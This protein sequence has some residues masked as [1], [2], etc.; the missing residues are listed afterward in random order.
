MKIEEFFSDLEA[1]PCKGLPEKVEN[2]WE[3]VNAKNDFFGIPESKI[4]G[5]LHGS[6]VVEGKVEIGD[7]V[8]VGP[9][10]VIEGPVKIGKNTKIRSCAWIRPYTIIGEDCVVGHGCEVK[11]ALIFNEAK[12][13]TNCFVGDSI[14]GKG[15]R[16]GSGTILGNRR[17]DQA[18]IYVKFN[19]E[20][21][22]TKTDKFGAVIGEYSRIGA[23][24]ATNPGTFI[25][26]HVWVSGGI[27]LAGFIPKNKFVSARAEIKLA[28]KEEIELKKEDMK[29]FR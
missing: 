13:G 12:L 6:V 9:F 3:M 1:C 28:D 8:E 11:N 4:R 26:K 20:K 10:V 23:N 14:L 24:V 25:G 2:A 18:V 19:G 17:F 27:A 21:I 5:R 7:G 22:S 15:A 16:L 29:G